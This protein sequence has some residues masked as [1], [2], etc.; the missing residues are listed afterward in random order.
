MAKPTFIQFNGINVNAT[1]YKGKNLKDFST[2]FKKDHKEN[3]EVELSADDL[4][5]LHDL[6]NAKPKKDE[7]DAPAAF[8]E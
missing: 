2:D 7:A 4:K 3:S 1:H 5:E 6:I 8:T